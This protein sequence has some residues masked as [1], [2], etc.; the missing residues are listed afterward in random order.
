[1]SLHERLRAARE[2]WAVGPVLERAFLRVTGKDAQDYLHR[3][4]TQDL[5]RLKPGEAAYAAFLNAKGHLLGEGHVLVR[6]GEIL[7]EL[8]PAA[9]PETR[10]LLEK[11]VIMDDV[12]FEDLSAT[13]R[14]LPVLGPEGP[15]RLAGR[16]G[17]APVVP[18]ARRG[19]PCVDVWAP[20][21][22]AEA[23]RA[24]LVADG[25]A[26]L[27]LAEL[28]SLR[29]L[30]GVARFGADMDASRLPMEA[31]LT[32]AAISFTKGCYIGQEVVLRATARG[33]L[34]RGLVQLELPPGA[35]PGTPLVAGGQ[36][37]GAVTSAAETPEG[38]L[39]LG[40]LRRA[41]WKPGER[42]RAGEGE[43]VVR[44]VIVEDG[45]VA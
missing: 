23:L 29:I 6:E 26:P 27:D 19:A 31:G 17:A 45:V 25:A 11:L 44:A 13:L 18:S 10:A 5:A 34:Q 38:R 2:G 12:T 22:E 37:V 14:A 3:M 28:E 21:G 8:D 35:G 40:Y 15:A 39:G 7:V 43:A 4:S 24:A 41:H 42:V 20:A 16:A 32:R 33:H 36:E 9:A 1:M 30:A